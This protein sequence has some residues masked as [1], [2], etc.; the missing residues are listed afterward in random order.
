M[1]FPPCEV[2]DVEVIMLPACDL[3]DKKSQE[4]QSKVLSIVT[5]TNNNTFRFISEIIGVDK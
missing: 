2:E 1:V 4:V 3:R 5:A